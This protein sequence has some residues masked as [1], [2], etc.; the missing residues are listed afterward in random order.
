MKPEWP[1]RN[2]VPIDDL[3]TPSRRSE[4]PRL[5]PF[6][7]AVRWFGSDGKRFS[8]NFKSRKEAEQYAEVK[9]AKVRMGNGDRPCAV[10]LIEF[11]RMYVE[12]RGDLAPVTRRVPEC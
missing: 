3:G 1:L 8:R 2:V 6:S 11:A 5:G 12:L 10:T 9:Q 7:W 4:W